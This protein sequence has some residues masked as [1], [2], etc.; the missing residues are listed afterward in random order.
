VKDWYGILGVPEGANED[1]LKLAYRSRLLEV[2]PDKQGDVDSAATSIEEVKN[3]YQILS[4]PSLK[5]QYDNQRN[6]KLS[7][8]INAG[9]LH[10]RQFEKSMSR[11][12]SRLFTYPCR[13]GEIYEISEDDLF[14]DADFLVQCNG[15]TLHV[16]VT[17]EG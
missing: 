14:E 7:K 5:Q 10:L 15:C 8:G 16:H 1:E 4:D 9:K 12:G 2:H 3:A 17:T 13:C 6:A 11:D